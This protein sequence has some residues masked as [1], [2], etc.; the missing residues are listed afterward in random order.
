MTISD[1][2]TQLEANNV[3]K[4]NIAYDKGKILDFV[5]RNFVKELL[6]EPFPLSYEQKMKL[7]SLLNNYKLY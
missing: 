5:Y 1:Y 7:Q 4:N 6:Q 2:N 3:L